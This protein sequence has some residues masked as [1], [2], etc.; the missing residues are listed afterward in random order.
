MHALAR[1]I[2]ISVKTCEY[3][4]CQ[5]VLHLNLKNNRNINAKRI[6]C[7]CYPTLKQIIIDLVSAGQ[8][9]DSENLT[10]L[11]L[12]F[13]SYT[14]R[15][16]K[17]CYPGSETVCSWSGSASEGKGECKRNEIQVTVH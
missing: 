16:G 5:N 14:E 2:F 11:L 8:L 17:Y 15:N 10:I 7:G 6:V 1:F 9:K 13:V 3:T 12:I 4:A